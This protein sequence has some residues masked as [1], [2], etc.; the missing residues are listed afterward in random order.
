MKIG[1]FILLVIISFLTIQPL[2]KTEPKKVAGCCSLKDH[3]RKKMPAQNKKS[4]CEG[5]GCN[6]FVGCPYYNLFLV[7]ES[8][9][10]LLLPPVKEKIDVNNDN[11][12]I[13]SISECWHPPNA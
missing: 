12:T 2:I 5:M 1:A 6:P 10:S 11:R 4:D 3:C 7:N 13:Q 8:S 9:L